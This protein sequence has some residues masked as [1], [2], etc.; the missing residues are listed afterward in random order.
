MQKRDDVRRIFGCG[1]RIPQLEEKTVVTPQSYLAA[2]HIQLVLRSQL[3]QARANLRFDVGHF[4]RED[5][6]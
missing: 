6:S 1:P 3:G 5:H 2:R 4:I